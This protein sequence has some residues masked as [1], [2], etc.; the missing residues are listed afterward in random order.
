MNDIQEERR[1]ILPVLPLRGLV[2][3]PEMMLH[4]DIGRKKSALAIDQ[5]MR[6]NQTIFITSQKDININDPKEADLYQTGVIARVV[7]V[8]KQPENIIRVVVEGLCR[9]SVL[10]YVKE[11]PFFTAEV[12]KIP[13][14]DREQNVTDL[15]LIRSAK[16]VFEQYVRLSPKMAADILYKVGMCNNA[17]TLA[18]FIAGN[19][20]L[21]YQDKQKVLETLDSR[22][23]LEQLI[24]YITNEVFILEIEETINQKARERIDEGQREYYLREQMRA[25]EEELG[26]DDDPAAEAEDYRDKVLALNLKEDTQKVLLKECDKLQKMPYGSQEANV[27]RTYLD[28]CI[29]LPWN[30]SSKER[31]DMKKAKAHLD[32]YHYGLSKVK[33]HILE[34]LAVRKLSPDVKGQILC[35]VGPPGV[36][37]TSI[38]QSIAGAINRK[39]QRIAL[40]GVHDESEIR[41]HRRTYIG[42]MPGRVMNAIKLAGTNNPVLILDEVDKLGSDYKGDPTSA[43]LEVLDS[44]QNSTFQDHYIDLPFDLS[45]VMF[46]TTAND[47]GA[48]PAPLLDRMDIME[49]P[50]YTREEKFHIAKKHL[51]PKQMKNCGLSGRT[52]RLSDGAIYELIDSYTREAGVRSLERRITDLLRKAAVKI[53]V[54][55]CKR[56]DIDNNCLESYLGPKKYKKELLG[57]VNEVGVANGLAWTS[58]GGETLPIEVA[59]VNGTGKIEL[60]G[61]LGDVMKESAKTAV[62]C[63]RSHAEQLH[64]EDDFYKKY[65]IHIHAPEGAVPKDGPS[66]GVTMATALVSALTNTPVRRDVA[67]TGEITLRGRILPI[68]GLKEKSMAAYRLGVNTVIIPED[69]KPDLSEIDSTVK[70]A[71]H[72]IPVSDFREA[73]SYALVPIE[74]TGEEQQGQGT[75]IPKT[76]TAGAA[77]GRIP[78]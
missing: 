34:L 78:Q 21:D 1:V 54:G 41:G 11:K 45:N 65:D 67:M 33:E 50:S 36:G 28:T 7:Q 9:A 59:V 71:L 75:I 72:F 35:L 13:T 14:D 52:F 10:T 37:K 32:K 16:N 17:G 27:V 47:A 3:F 15:A 76:K 29:E 25:I 6:T 49:L 68:G 64:I 19:I 70:D 5:A 24:G 22:N 63:V 44:E 40:G 55:E 26:E 61:S 73:L 30:T 46:I 39:S 43:L 58:V 57:T 48:I 31:I 2:L 18:D 23:R 20:I 60:T 8:L 74:K 66:A 42:S 51:L 53:V 62:T 12:E 4:F 77:V 69:N 56:V 38:A